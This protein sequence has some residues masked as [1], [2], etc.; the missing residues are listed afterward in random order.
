MPWT[1]SYCEVVL[2]IEKREQRVSGSTVYRKCP[3]LYVALLVLCAHTDNPGAIV[4]EHKVKA[5][6]YAG[7]TYCFGRSYYPGGS[8]PDLSGK[9][10]DERS[11]KQVRKPWFVLFSF[12]FPF[13]II[14]AVHFIHFSVWR[15]QSF[16][17]SG[18]Q[19]IFEQTLKL[20]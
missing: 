17:C 18:N 8:I 13:S 16:A 10:E 6:D 2:Y 3:H 7:T 19:L 20:A 15:L 9:Q 5:P 1:T 4:D 12:H 14:H 11:G